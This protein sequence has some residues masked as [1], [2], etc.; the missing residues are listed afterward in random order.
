MSKSQVNISVLLN[1]QD[2]TPNAINDHVGKNHLSAAS[3]D[4]LVVIDSAVDDYSLL[5]SGVQQGAH[6]VVLEKDHNGVAQISA[7][8]EAYGA[9]KSLHIVCHGSPGCLYLGNSQLSL[10]TL[11]HYAD[12]IASWSKR[13]SGN[14]LLLYGCRVAAGDAGEE[15]VDKIHRL[16]QATVA[17]SANPVGDARQGG[18]WQLASF[19]GGIKS[20]QAFLPETQQIYAGI[21]TEVLSKSVDEYDESLIIHWLP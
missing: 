5:V 4:M 20:A 11:T 9:I 15:F 14:E 2:I 1:N 17:A 21:F 19:F 12:Q 7:A 13:L 18:T 16:T 3:N 6:V 8:L 10:K